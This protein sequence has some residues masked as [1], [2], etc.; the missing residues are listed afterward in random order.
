MTTA[1]RFVPEV[2]GR[3]RRP[4]RPRVAAG[5]LALVALTAVVVPLVTDPNA[6]NLDE[7]LAAPSWHHLFGTDALGRDTAARVLAGARISLAVAALSTVVSVLVGA[8]LGLW[9]GYRGGRVDAVVSYA[10]DT[11]LSIPMF[12]VLVLLGRWWGRELVPL[13]LIIGLTNWMPVARLVRT[14]TLSLR[15]RTFIEAARGLGFA[16]P[17]ILARHV[18]PSVAAPIGVAA[19]V[20]AAQAMLAEAAL[21]YLGFGLA[22]PTP[23]WG[24]MLNEAQAEMWRSAWLALF[25]G[26]FLFVSTLCLHGI[27]DGIRDAFDP[28]AASRRWSREE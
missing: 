15:D 16:T 26:A 18:L 4:A 7:R 8:T 6:Q 19:A 22:P 23:S 10:V 14:A 9:A 2:R 24:R 12:F 5:L 17:R 25:P 28:R 20:A 27:A 1:M 13:C 21:G 11:I 3:P